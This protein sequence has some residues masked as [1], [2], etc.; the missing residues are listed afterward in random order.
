MYL[1]IFS[2]GR[3][4]STS[5]NFQTVVFVGSMRHES[6]QIKIL[7][8]LQKMTKIIPRFSVPWFLIWLIPVNSCLWT[9][10]QGMKPPCTPVERTLAFCC[11]RLTFCRC[12]S[13]YCC[14]G[15]DVKSSS[16]QE[17]YREELRPWFLMMFEAIYLA[18][19]KDCLSF[20]A[21]LER[22]S[23]ERTFLLE[24]K[25][26]N[27]ASHNSSLFRASSPENSLFI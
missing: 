20:L 23:R 19:A 2:F 17:E 12:F 3:V 27:L 16:H 10:R 7:I 18:S 24:A 5:G 1:V 25:A 21:G 8:V 22:G 14:R 11:V 15:Q 6:E 9:L 26:E 4:Y 13:E